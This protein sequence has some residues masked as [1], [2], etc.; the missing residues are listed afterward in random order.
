MQKV[1]P[2]T[3][4]DTITLFN[5]YE[6]PQ[7]NL[8]TWHRTIIDKC[9]W[10]NTGNKI[11][12]GSVVIGTNDIICRIPE[13]DN[14]MEKHN[15][16]NIPNDMMHKYFTLGIGDIIVRDSVQDDINE[17]VSGKRSSDLINKYKNLQG[18][19]LIEQMS[20]NTG[21]GRCAPHYFAK[22]V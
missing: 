6:D 12:I 1:Y 8:I 5:K 2:I 11:N 10:K 22:G 3:W 17:Y 20:I 14:F 16:I 19:F 9:F 7:T 15:W 21:I 4:T 13:N 18:C